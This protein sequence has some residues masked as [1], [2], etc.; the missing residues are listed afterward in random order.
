[1]AGSQGDAIRGAADIVSR[2]ARFMNICS[3]AA[4]VAAVLA[5][6]MGYPARVV[7][8]DGHTVTSIYAGRKWITLDTYGNVIFRDSAGRALDVSE[9]QSTPSAKARRVVPEGTP[10]LPEYVPE[11]GGLIP[12][13]RRLYLDQWLYVVFTGEDLFT[14][15]EDSHSLE[16]VTESVF[17]VDA[18]LAAQL[19]TGRRVGNVGAYFFTRLL[20][21]V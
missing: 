9:L 1:M 15:A 11:G 7:W 20:P 6:A 3:E 16:G 8:M 21:P 2:D 17:G 19:D 10:G 4:K 5:Q 18:P 14:F 13:A 12:Y